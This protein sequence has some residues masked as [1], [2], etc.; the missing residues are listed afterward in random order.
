MIRQISSNHIVLPRLRGVALVLGALALSGCVQTATAP[1]V[2]APPPAAA[3]IAPPVPR[4]VTPVTPVTP[5]PAPAPVAP[6]A[7]GPVDSRTGLHQA[8]VVAVTGDADSRF[9]VLFRPSLT[10]PSNVEAA[11]AAICRQAGRSVESSRTNAPGGASAM[12]GVQIMI[13]ECTAA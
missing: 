11:P 8:A 13:V 12:P 2:T 4:T 9:T 7:T 6:V 1:V 10:A 3:P 5:P